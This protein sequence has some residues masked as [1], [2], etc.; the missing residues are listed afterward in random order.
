MAQAQLN[1]LHTDVT[2]AAAYMTLGTLYQ[3]IGRKEEALACQD[4]ALLHGQMFHQP[5]ASGE[6]ATLKLLVFVVQGDLMA[7]TPIELLLEGRPVEITRLYVDS[8]V[9]LEH[10]ADGAGQVGHVHHLGLGVDP[11]GRQYGLSDHAA[12]S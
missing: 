10:G 11:A 12:V 6:A 1:R 5:T 9:P 4:A 8:V 2:D 7:N 3:L